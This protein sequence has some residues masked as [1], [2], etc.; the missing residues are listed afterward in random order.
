MRR[1]FVTATLAAICALLALSLTQRVEAQNN[2]T[3]PSLPS[4]PLPQPGSPANPFGA[5][6]SENFLVTSAANEHGSYLWI[7]APVQH[8]VILCEKVDQAKTFSCT[9]QRL[10]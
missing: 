5:I 10:P 8:F 9:T 2:G 3:T 4:A 7:V 6:A 1:S